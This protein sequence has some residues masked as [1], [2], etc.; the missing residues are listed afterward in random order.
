MPFRNL[1]DA[2]SYGPETLKALGQAFD[3]AWRSVEGNFG[4]DPRAVAAARQKLAKAL[5]SVAAEDSRDVEVLKKGALEALAESYAAR[6]P[7]KVPH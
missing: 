1:M 5:L 2:C 7:G 6:I 4:S 3:E